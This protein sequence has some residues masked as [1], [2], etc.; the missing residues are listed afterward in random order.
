M[1]VLQ[2]VDQERP[3]NLFETGDL[4]RERVDS[5]FPQRF[6]VKTEAAIKTFA[7]PMMSPGLV[8]SNI[9]DVNPFT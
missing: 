7:S 6:E 9:P 2:N 4:N 5:I 8:N 1:P 3:N